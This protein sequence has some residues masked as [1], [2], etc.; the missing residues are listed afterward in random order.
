[1]C[2]GSLPTKL[3]WLQQWF[4]IK[5]DYCISFQGAFVL[6]LP[7]PRL[8][9]PLSSLSF[10]IMAILDTIK[11][12]SAFVPPS[13]CFFWSSPYVVL[14]LLIM[15]QLHLES[16]IKTREAVMTG[17]AQIVKTVPTAFQYKNKGIEKGAERLNAVL[18]IY[19]CVSALLNFLAMLCL[20]LLSYYWLHTDL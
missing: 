19:E 7:P 5:Q 14:M 20:Y 18:M 17:T 13:S 1:M 9:F 2:H 8:F 3:N 16:S 12:V 11:T 10:W 6:H 4:R 15:L